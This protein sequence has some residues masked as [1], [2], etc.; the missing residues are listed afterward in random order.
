MK[1]TIT[2]HFPICPSEQ[3]SDKYKVADLI[4]YECTLFDQLTKENQ[5]QIIGDMLER[6]QIHILSILMDEEVVELPFYSLD[7]LFYNVFYYNIYRFRVISKGNLINH[8]NL[9][10]MILEY[11]KKHANSVLI[12]ENWRKRLETAEKVAKSMMEHEDRYDF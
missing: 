11:V 10:S 8:L 4:F 2:K 7:D 9:E 12:S 3:V 6:N 5:K 1:K